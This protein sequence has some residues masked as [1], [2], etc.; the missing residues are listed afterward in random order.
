MQLPMP[1]ESFSPPIKKV[2][3]KR[4][5]WRRLAAIE[6]LE[7]RS[8]LAAVA[9]QLYGVGDLAGFERVGADLQLA[10]R[11]GN[12]APANEILS[13]QITGIR[14]SWG[15]VRFVQGAAGTYDAA[16]GTWTAMGIT[17]ADGAYIE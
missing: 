9:P 11:H 3:L 6:R 10:V 7:P 14:S 2:R 12:Q 13:V 1:P 17:N 4:G 15:S 5:T 16:N 8:L